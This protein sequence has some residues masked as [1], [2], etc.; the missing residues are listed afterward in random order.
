LGIFFFFVVVVV[1]DVALSLVSF[2]VR[3]PESSNPDS[4]NETESGLIRTRM[5]RTERGKKEE[6]TLSFLTIRFTIE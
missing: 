4:E 6:D 3:H 5:R 2:N 1:V